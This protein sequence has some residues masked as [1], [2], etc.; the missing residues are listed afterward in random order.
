MKIK[1]H[2]SFLFSEFSSIEFKRYALPFKVISQALVARTT[3]LMILF[4]Y[5]HDGHFWQTKF[6]LNLFSLKYL[7]SS[8]SSICVPSALLVSVLNV[9]EFL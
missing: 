8:S 2:R 1:L 5:T 7:T 6:I 3:P 9:C 4:K